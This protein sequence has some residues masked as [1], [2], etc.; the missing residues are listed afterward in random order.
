MV[1]GD[2][3]NDIPDLR[4]VDIVCLDGYRLEGAASRSASG[5]DRMPNDGVTAILLPRRCDGVGAMPTDPPAD[6]RQPAIARLA[7]LPA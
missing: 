1:D 3:S 5:L 6:D 2:V 7:S 4:H